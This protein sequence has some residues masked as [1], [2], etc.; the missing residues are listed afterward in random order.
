MAYRAAEEVE[1][2]IK[3]EQVACVEV[4]K[5]DKRMLHLLLQ[6]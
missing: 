2:E 6:L 1:M 5:V 4:V 3:V